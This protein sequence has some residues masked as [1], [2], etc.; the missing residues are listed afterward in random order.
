MFNKCIGKMEN[1]DLMSPLRVWTQQLK[2]GF[3]VAFDNSN[4]GVKESVPARNTSA[5]FKAQLVSILNKN[6]TNDF[7]NFRDFS[8]S[9]A[10]VFELNKQ[11]FT[12]NFTSYNVSL[13]IVNN[14]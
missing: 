1:E 5:Q 11:N 8:Q 10:I 3:C 7:I 12:K 4:V 13:L 9:S 14:I 2:L 6:N